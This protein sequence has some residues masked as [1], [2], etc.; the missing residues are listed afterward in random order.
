VAQNRLARV[1]AYGAGVKEDPLEATM[2]HL[3][4]RSAGVSDFKLDLYITKLTPE[5]R[6]K[7]EK[8]AEAWAIR[9]LG[10]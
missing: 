6:I 3:L 9:N 10:G 4:A 7:A 5:Q 1:Y 8:A 2:W